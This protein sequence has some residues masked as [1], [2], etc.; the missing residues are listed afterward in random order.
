MSPSHGMDFSIDIRHKKELDIAFCYRL[1]MGLPKVAGLQV[2]APPIL[3][4]FPSSQVP[5]EKGISGLVMMVESH[6]GLHW[7][8]EHGY[9]HITISSCKGVWVKQTREYL[10][11]M[12][13]TTDIISKMQMWEEKG[14][15]KTQHIADI[16]KTP[17]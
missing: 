13:G 15:G 6:I 1:L 11:V 2:L 4:E 10:E 17:V 3:Y 16:R 12:F 9:T 5:T 7:W 8:P 14:E